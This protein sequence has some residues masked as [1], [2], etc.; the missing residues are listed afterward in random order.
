MNTSSRAAHGG[1]AID[2]RTK[3]LVALAIS[4]AVRYDPNIA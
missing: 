4:D 1:G 2:A 3:E